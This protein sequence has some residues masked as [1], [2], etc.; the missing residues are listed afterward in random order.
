MTSIG[1]G[2]FEGCNKLQYNEYDNAYYL[3]NENN[4]YLVLI[5]AK[6]TSITSC[7]INNNT[8]VIAGEAFYECSS[9][10]SITIPDSVTSIG[11]Y[12]F[13]YCSNLTSI[14][15]NG[16]IEQWNAISKGE[17]WKYN[18]PSKVYCTDGTISI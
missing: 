2:A 14:T 12:A 4:P 13:E 6:N 18:I 5:K 7:N 1:D 15:F 11:D 9:L 3:G 17:R 16:T 8:K 10:T